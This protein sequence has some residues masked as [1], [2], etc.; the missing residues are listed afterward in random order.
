MSELE[1]GARCRQI[2]DDARDDNQSQ[3]AFC[4]HVKHHYAQSE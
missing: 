2:D 1:E 4:A 3:Y